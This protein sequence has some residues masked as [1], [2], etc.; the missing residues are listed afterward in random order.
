M[1]KSI[2]TIAVAAGLLTAA[3]T[4][5]AVTTPLNI[6]IYGASAQFAFLTAAADNIL[7]RPRLAPAPL[8]GPSPAPSSPSPAIPAAAAPAPTASPLGSP[9]NPLPTA[10]K[11]ILGTASGNGCS[12]NYQRAFLTTPGDAVDTS[13][14]NVTLAA[15]DVAP[16]TFNEVTNGCEFGPVRDTPTSGFCAAPTANGG[17]TCTTTTGQGKCYLDTKKATPITATGVTIKNP[18]I[19]PFAFWANNT[20]Q[21]PADVPT[22]PMPAASAIRAPAH[23]R[24]YRSPWQFRQG[25]LRCRPA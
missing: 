16:G 10:S 25:Q 22:P 13:C 20:L 19:V 17:K 23:P 11:A 3:G 9:T 18:M 2:K 4:A 6:N 12:S 7:Q 14:Q 8:T 1:K 15:S 21:E 5:Q 24:W